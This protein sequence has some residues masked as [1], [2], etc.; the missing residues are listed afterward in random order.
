M[1][2]LL[3]SLLKTTMAKFMEIEVRVKDLFYVIFFLLSVVA[4]GKSSW[5]GLKDVIF[6]FKLRIFANTVVEQF[7]V[8]HPL[9]QIFMLVSACDIS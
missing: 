3:K 4:C 8:K 9:L 5:S 6:M 1:A 7:N 2:L